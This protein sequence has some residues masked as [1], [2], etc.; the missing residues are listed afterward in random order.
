MTH[1]VRC[2]VT[3]RSDIL[4]FREHYAQCVWCYILAFCLQM[5]LSK[6]LIPNL[7]W[8]IVWVYVRECFSEQGIYRIRNSHC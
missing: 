2:E 8:A 3:F 4:N 7:L 6:A 5:P 1:M